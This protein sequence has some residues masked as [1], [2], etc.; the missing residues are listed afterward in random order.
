MFDHRLS[1]L[2]LLS[3]LLLKSFTPVFSESALLLDPPVDPAT[4][5][6]PIE[7]EPERSR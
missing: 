4:G 3:W 2:V 7:I 5:V 1:L 6:Q